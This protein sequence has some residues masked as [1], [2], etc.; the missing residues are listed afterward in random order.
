MVLSKG[1]N[2]LVTRM[3]VKGQLKKKIPCLHSNNLGKQ[4]RMLERLNV[5]GWG[6]GSVKD[7]KDTP[8][9]FG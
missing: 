4:V 3:S 5:T 6:C 9:D 7:V 8:Q 1:M 2:V